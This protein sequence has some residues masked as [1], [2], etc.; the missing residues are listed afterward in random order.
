[1][2]KQ[3]KFAWVTFLVMV[4]GSAWLAWLLW[5]TWPDTATFREHE[6][7]TRPLLWAVLLLCGAVT[8]AQ[9][10]WRPKEPF[11]DERDRAILHA[12]SLQGFATLALMNVVLG[13]V[14]AA[15]DGLLARLD[16][17]WMRYLLLLQVGVAFAVASGYRIVRYRLG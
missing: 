5:S 1:M 7:L 3:E 11:A 16:A 17:V 15:N 6:A 14:I 10:K 12:G 4:I 8:V 13:I 2:S 9:L